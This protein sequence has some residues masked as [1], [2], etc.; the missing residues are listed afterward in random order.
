M[1][2]LEGL[3]QCNKGQSYK[4]GQP[5]HSF[6]FFFTGIHTQ[7]TLNYKVNGTVSESSM[8][9]YARDTYFK[10]MS[11]PDGDACR[12]DR[13]LKDACEMDWPDSPSEPHFRDD[14][15]S[16]SILSYLSNEKKRKHSFSDEE[17]PDIIMLDSL[18]VV[19]IDDGT[20]PRDNTGGSSST[21][22]HQ[23]HCKNKKRKKDNTDL[24]VMQTVVR[25]RR[26]ILLW[27]T[28]K[29]RQKKTWV[30]SRFVF[31]SL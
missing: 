8:I 23:F 25:A 30:Q 20:D 27:M 9:G 1:T 15:D 29:K 2:V 19:K 31:L 28:Q 7:M 21:T 11:K 18:A 10:D 5:Q 13:T 3:D 14:L 12:E 6:Q 16:I 26:K 4:F 17:D 22:Q 24:E